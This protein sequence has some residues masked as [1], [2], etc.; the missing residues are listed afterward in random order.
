MH[1]CPPSGYASVSDDEDKYRMM[2]SQSQGMFRT[3]LSNHMNIPEFS[4][5]FIKTKLH[6]NTVECNVCRRSLAIY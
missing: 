5:L 1:Q 4:N 6:N 2:N 3:L